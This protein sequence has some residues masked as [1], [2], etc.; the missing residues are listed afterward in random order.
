MEQSESAWR[1]ER[2]VP[3]G[4]TRPL[5]WASALLIGAACAPEEPASEAAPTEQVSVDD[6]NPPTARWRQVED[7]K[8]GQAAVVHAA[9]GG[10]TATLVAADSTQAVRAGERGSYVLQLIVGEHGIAAGGGIYLMPD[11]FWGWS[12]PQAQRADAP[13]YTTVELRSG[14]AELAPESIPGMLFVR[15]VAGSLE[16]N[17]E[18]ILHYGAGPLG[19]KVDRYAERGARLWLAVD[20]DGDGFRRILPDSPAVDIL[21]HSATR[22]AVTLSSV[23]R[24]GEQ[25][26]L[27][28]AALDPGGNAAI[29]FVGEVALDGV[30]SEWDLPAALAIS[31]EDRGSVRRQF[32]VQTEGVARVSATAEVD[33]V[34]LSGTSNPLVVSST[35]PSVHWADL[36]GHSNYSDGTGLPEDYFRYARDFAALDIVSLTDHDHFGVRFLDEAPELWEDIK[37]L[38]KSFHEP[39]TFVT[40]LGYEWTSWIHG[41]RHVIYF[42]DEGEVLSSLDP[43]TENPRQL[44]SKLAG[45]K[46]LTYAHHSAGEPVATNWSYAPDPELE[47]VTEVMSVHGSSEAADSPATVRGA[48]RGNFVR[49]VLD[50]GVRLGFIG[51]GDS[52]DGHPGLPHMTPSYGYLPPR[53]ALPARMGTGGLA[54]IVGAELS[55][56]GVLRAMKARSVYATSGPRTLL[57]VQLGGVASGGSISPAGEH[58]LEIDVIAQGPLDRIDLIRSGEIVQSSALGSDLQFTGTAPL[59][60]LTSGEYVYVRVIQAD[61]GLAWSSPIWID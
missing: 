8:A 61:G 46:V 6:P 34:P 27:T 31:A 37:R 5:F 36:H 28:V 33:G 35:L 24:P 44:W 23:V 32:T 43:E 18:V 12:P 11:P 48:R 30:P 56:E 39:G 57:F 9:D 26:Q 38:T 22:F 58:K 59:N 7:L 42:E 45:K 17:D 3:Q 40:L 13:G 21:P 14:T 51:S 53:A 1:G 52:H 10:G 2:W 50:R 19:V 16:A 49:D 55:R 25:G 15:V 4:F 54:A 47:P 60:D 41:H 20:G 29:D